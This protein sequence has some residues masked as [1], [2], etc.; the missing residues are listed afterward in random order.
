MCRIAGTIS[1][2]LSMIDVTEIADEIRLEDEVTFIGPR[3]TCWDW[4]TALGTI[5]YEITCLIGARIPRVYKKDGK[6]CDVYYP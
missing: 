1:M 4:A 6:I 2:D 5:P 3:T